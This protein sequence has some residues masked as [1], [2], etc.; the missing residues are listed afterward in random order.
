M[1]ALYLIDFYPCFDSHFLE[2]QIITTG[3]EG[4]WLLSCFKVTHNFATRSLLEL[5]QCQ[6]TLQFSWSWSSWCWIKQEITEFCSFMSTWV[7][8]NLTYLRIIFLVLSDNRDTVRHWNPAFWEGGREVSSSS[9]EMWNICEKECCLE[10]SDCLLQLHM[11]SEQAT[12]LPT[13][14]SRLP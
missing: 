1:E 6:N 7:C 13:S 11:G 10:G 3:P 9:W 4:K 14:G 8:M 12:Q 5:D 2:T